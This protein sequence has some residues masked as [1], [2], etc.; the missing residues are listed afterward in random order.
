MV[1]GCWWCFVC[2]GILSRR[3]CLKGDSF[4]SDVCVKGREKKGDKRGEGRG[5][6]EEGTEVGDRTHHGKDRQKEKTERQRA[7]KGVLASATQ[8]RGKR[9]KSRESE[10]KE[11]GRLRILR[12][13]TFYIVQPIDS[14]ERR[15]NAFFFPL[16]PIIFQ[17]QEKKPDSVMHQLSRCPR[18]DAEMQRCSWI[19]DHLRET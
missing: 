13:G 9:K 12:K 11:K 14:I 4:L 10:G 5:G 16:S 8:G 6:E 18:R 1:L 2:C 3:M 15:N 17:V 7:S 19:L